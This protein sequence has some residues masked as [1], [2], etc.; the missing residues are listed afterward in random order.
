MQQQLESRKKWLRWNQL[1]DF[2][3]TRIQ[4]LTD[5]ILW[6]FWA[7]CRKREQ[8]LNISAIAH[9]E[10]IHEKISIDS[11]FLSNFFQTSFFLLLECLRKTPESLVE[12]SR[13]QSLSI[14]ELV[15]ITSCHRILWRQHHGHFSSRYR[16]TVGRV[17]LMKGERYI[18]RA[19]ELVKF[20]KHDRV[21]RKRY[22]Y[23]PS[24]SNSTAL[25]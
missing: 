9:S 23:L 10:I 1:A 7:S 13:V 11:S 2:T 6:P 15:F 3:D 14:Y 5:F 25:R 17:R 20:G 22:N 24:S 12:F 21:E 19:M 8:S 4:S 16:Q 18:A